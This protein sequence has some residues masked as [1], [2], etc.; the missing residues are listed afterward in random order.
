MAAD[1]SKMSC[2]AGAGLSLSGYTCS[3]R[4]SGD[5]SSGRAAPEGSL[6]DD[7]PGSP[8]A[9]DRRI[10]GG[11]ACSPQACNHSHDVNNLSCFHC[12]LHSACQ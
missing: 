12:D 9:T 5:S 3:G 6:S 1:M 4:L 2:G 7:G 10:S 8:M 11:S